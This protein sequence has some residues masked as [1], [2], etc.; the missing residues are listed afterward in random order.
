MVNDLPPRQNKRL[1]QGLSFSA[2]FSTVP[3][4]RMPRQ[5]QEVTVKNHPTQLLLTIRARDLRMLQFS[6]LLAA[7]SAAMWLEMPATKSVKISKNRIARHKHI[8][9]VSTIIVLIK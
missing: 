1:T 5:S 9:I 6:Y 3:E 4:Q 2:V 7:I 8:L